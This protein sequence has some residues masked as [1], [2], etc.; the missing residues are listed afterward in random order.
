MN[1]VMLIIKATGTIKVH[2]QRYRQ[3][4]QRLGIHLKSQIKSWPGGGG[5]RTLGA[6]AN[7]HKARILLTLQ[8]LLGLCVLSLLMP[9]S[10]LRNSSAE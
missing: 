10:Q 8:Y 7:S 4:K 2:L 3:V 5:R 6:W 9:S 1:T